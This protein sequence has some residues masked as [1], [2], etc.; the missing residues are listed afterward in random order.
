MPGFT[1]S[2]KLLFRLIHKPPQI[3]YALGLGPLIGRWILLLTTTGR[4]SG[5]PRVVPLQYEVVDGRYYLGAARGGKADW[6]RNLLADP[7]V[8]MR[9]GKSRLTGTAEV[10]TAPNRFVDFLAVR[11][12]RHPRMIGMMARAGGLPDAPNRADLE[13]Y[14]ADRALAVITPDP[15]RA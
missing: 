6:V 12:R 2:P 13:R 15:H 14:A 4:K 8:T 5:K 7:R 10:V 11:M 9:V 1:Q 3:A